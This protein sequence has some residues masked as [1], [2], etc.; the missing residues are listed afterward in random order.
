MGIDP[1]HDADI[2]TPAT[3]GSASIAR[4]TVFDSED[5]GSISKHNPLALVAKCSS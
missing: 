4:A 5:L 1:A 3:R 2:G